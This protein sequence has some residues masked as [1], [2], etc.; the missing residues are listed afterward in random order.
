MVLTSESPGR[1]LERVMVEGAGDDRCEGAFPSTLDGVSGGES[2]R[3][4][5]QSFG[6]FVNANA[7]CVRVVASSEIFF[8][9][10]LI[11]RTYNRNAPV[12]RLV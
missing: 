4:L 6:S 1:V 5:S 7:C 2:K 11:S 9:V 3:V 10:F 8:V 12:T